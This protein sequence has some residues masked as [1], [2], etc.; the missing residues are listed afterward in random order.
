MLLLL[1]RVLGICYND[2]IPYFSWACVYKYKN[3]LGMC[4]GGVEF[5][6]LK[7]SK[8][9]AGIERKEMRCAE[10]GGR[11]IGNRRKVRSKV[12]S[13]VLKE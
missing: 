13:R 10:E 1:L 8:Q 3:R 11:A 2:R 5:K 9:S 6:K 7:R 4:V 12:V